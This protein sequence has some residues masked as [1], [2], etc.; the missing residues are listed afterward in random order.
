ML[1]KLI[2]IL[3]LLPSILFAQQGACVF[4]DWSKHYGGTKAD[5]ANDMQVTADSGLIVVGYSRSADEDLSNNKG[6]S[7]YW[8]LKLDMLGNIEWQQNYGGADNDIATGVLQTADGGYIV[9]GGSVSFDGQVSGNH[10]VEDA[11]VLRL[12][13]VGNILWKKAYGGSLNERVESIQPTSDGGYILAGYSQ[14]NNGDLT[15]NHGEFDYWVLKIDADGNLIWQRNLG[16]SL[17]EYAFDAVQ[18]TDGGYLVAGSSFSSDFDL[19]GNN[20][21][22][23]YWIAKLDASGN[24]DWQKN[25]GGNGEER[26]YDVEINAN[27][28]FIAGSSNSATID[29]NGNN[30]GYDVW[31]MK[32]ASDGSIIWSENYGGMTEDRAFSIIGKADGGLLLSGLSTSSNA[33]V[34]SNYGSKDGW[35]I[36]LDADGSLIWER[37]FG[38]SLDDRF[39]SVVQRQNGGFA[40]AGFSASSDQD[41]DGNYGE[42]DFWV[43]SLTP[44][45][46]SIDLGADTILCAGQGIILDPEITDVNYL[47]STGATSNV[48]L[49]SSP[50]EYWLEVDKEG[51]KSRDTM[52]VDYVS[53]VPVSLGNDTTLCEGQTILLDPDIPGADVVWKNGSLEPILEVGL[54]G[55]YWVEVS[56]AGCE[57]RDTI[58]I[59]F[60]TVPFDLGDDI[61]LCQGETKQLSVD[62]PDA[63]YAW[64][65]GSTAPDFTVTTPGLLWARV[66]Q[67]GCSRTDSVLVTIQDGPQDPMSDYGYICENEGIWFNVKYDEATYLWQDG[68][69]NHNFKAVAPGKYK[70]AVTINGCLFE[71][72]TELLPCEQCLYIPNVFSPNGDGINDEFRM[73]PGCEIKDFEAFIYDRWGNLVFQTDSPALSWNG[74]QKD[75]KVQ[76][77]V[78]AY[79]VSFG[80]DNNGEERT[81]TRIGTLT[82]LR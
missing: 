59:G 20:G 30:G 77:G 23:D 48:L 3:F 52:I 8:V 19:T 47:W 29:V 50:A 32:I 6:L 72:E 81:Q 18:T 25:F 15:D 16:G 7:D 65:D 9:A 4:T 46:L 76:T 33:D 36:N 61:A 38:G 24:L 21:F 68:S 2:F 57:Y 70:V 64:S 1:R 74:E 11:W 73:F 54:P 37:N 41:L 58:E 27:G 66:T 40:C 26:A 80:F 43:V 13:A 12:D 69:T 63:T 49:V 62:L 28:A 82:L 56:K 79:R 60:T 39:F 45:S 14:S 44:D 35:L 55:T 42:Q 34:S 17:S 31:V 71:D 22:Y 5:A 67:S 10:G 53:E 78:Y 75:R 51:C